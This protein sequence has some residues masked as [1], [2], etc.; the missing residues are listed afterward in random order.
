VAVVFA[1]VSSWP[2]VG[3]TP[4]AQVVPGV[5]FTAEGKQ[6]ERR[7]ENPPLS[8]IFDLACRK[9]LRAPDLRVHASGSLL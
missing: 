7:S 1:V 5:G 6:A 9:T 3:H 2:V 8:A 4:G